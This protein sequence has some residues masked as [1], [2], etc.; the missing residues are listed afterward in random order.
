MNGKSILVVGGGIAGLT[1]AIEAAEAGC[2]VVLIEKS[3]YLGGRVAGFHQYFPKLC[4]P[5]CGLEINFK[6]LKANPGVTVLTQA[7]LE[8]LSGSPG[9]YEAVIRIAP[10]HVT[11]ACTLCDDCS[12]V[13]PAEIADEFN[14][15]LTTTKTI[16]LPHRNAF[17]ARYVIDRTACPPDCHACV[18]ACKY[19]A[20]DLQQ[21]PAK[22]TLRVASVVLATG[23]APYDATKIDNLG[24]GKYANVVTNVILERL[25]SAD[26]PTKGKILRPS[27]GKEPKAVAFVQCAGSRDRNHLPYCSAVCCTASLKHATYVRSQYPEAKITMF[28]I[29]LRTPGHLEEFAAKVIAANGVEVIKGKVGKVQEH[30]VSRDLLLSAEDVLGGRKIQREYD[31]VV[32]ATGMVPRTTGIPVGVSLDEFGFAANGEP[33]VYAAGCAKRPAEVAASIRDATGSALKA[34]QNTR[35]VPNRGVA[36]GPLPQAGVTQDGVTQ[37]G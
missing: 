31:L 15:S 21:L 17:P 30:P 2:E 27:D 6:R 32:L 28:Y 4:P 20:I 34:L 36:Q 35:S 9:S 5:S 12:K 18:D 23:W 8:S 11:D 16:R 7:E 22:R 10:R 19:R 14:C 24:F 33:G 3:A 1:T 13:C 37:N 25:A 29:D 26:G